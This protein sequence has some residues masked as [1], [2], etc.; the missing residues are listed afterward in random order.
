MKQP[1]NPKAF[2]TDRPILPDMIY[3]LQQDG[4][5][6]VGSAGSF[7]RMKLEGEWKIMK[8]FENYHENIK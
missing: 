5:K 4:V 7:E 6:K 2:T 8:C 3:L 1:Q